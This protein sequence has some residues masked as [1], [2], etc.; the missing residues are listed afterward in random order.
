MLGYSLALQLLWVKAGTEATEKLHY[1]RL[2][3]AC[4]YGKAAAFALAVD[5]DFLSRFC[6]AI[7]EIV[8]E[9]NRQRR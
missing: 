2:A 7:G 4:R 1:R 5:G 8:E 6:E 9:E 3:Y